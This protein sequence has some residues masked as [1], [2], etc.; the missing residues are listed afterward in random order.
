MHEQI[1]DYLMSLEKM[2][3]AEGTKEQYRKG[4]DLYSGWLEDE[5]LEPMEV[6]GRDLQRYLG[7]MKAEKEYAPK[8]IRVKFVAV[9]RFYADLSSNGGSY[10]NPAKDV[11]MAD[12][13][14]KRTRKAEVTK[15]RRVWLSKDEVRKLVENVP[16][17]ALRNRLLILFQYYTGLRRQ[18]VCDVKL[19]DLDREERKVQIRGKGGKIHTAHWQPKLDGLLTAWLDGGY[20]KSS[21]YA[22]ESEYLFLTNSSSG[23][24]GSQLNDIIKL[25]AEKAGIQKVLFEDAAGREHY[26]VTSHT[27]KHSFAMHFLKN[28]GTMEGLSKLL[29][30][31]SVKT[32]E[33]YGEI[34]DERAEEEY[35]KYAPNIEF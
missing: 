8:T 2:D 32:T 13:A 28:G 10:D 1:E 20:R 27:L 12:Y 17:P 29:A 26:K 19:D 9:R 16:A 7:W 11:V 5:G 22:E 18:E 35:E 24:S 6:D 3:K 21:P 33:I 31:S 25:A 15:E 4:L 30:H 14:P 34:L 23:L